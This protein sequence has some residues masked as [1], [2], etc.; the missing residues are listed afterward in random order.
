MT[1][2]FY[3]EFFI[4]YVSFLLQII[5]SIPQRNFQFEKRTPNFHT[6]KKKKIYYFHNEI[7]A[8]ALT[9]CLSILH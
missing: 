6:F 2:N 3:I 5:E 1:W 7:V 8:V 9:N 4:L